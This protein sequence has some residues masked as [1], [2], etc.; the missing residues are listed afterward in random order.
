MSKTSLHI[1]DAIRYVTTNLGKGVSHKTWKKGCY[2]ICTS[3]GNFVF[4]S[5]DGQFHFDWL[6]RT[7]PKTGWMIY[8]DGKR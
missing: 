3:S 6:K 5:L 4:V 7:N 8:D 1:H 2:V